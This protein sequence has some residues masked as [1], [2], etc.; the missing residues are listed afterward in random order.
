[1][2]HF[3]II[4]IL[5]ITVTLQA[6]Q[7][8]SIKGNIQ[9]IKP[10]TLVFLM[11]GSDG[12]TIATDTVKNGQF[13]LKGK[14]AEPDIFQVGFVGFKEAI[15]LFMENNAIVIDGDFNSLNNVTIKGSAIEQD[16]L[17]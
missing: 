8:F 14:V 9:N 10:G 16:Y 5:F 11:N 6:Q 15:D 17:D 12:K 13:Q 2:R 1:M 4:S 7:G 3:F